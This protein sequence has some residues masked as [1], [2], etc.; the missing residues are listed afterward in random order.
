VQGSSRSRALRLTVTA[1]FAG[2]FVAGAVAVFAA[3]RFLGA[4][5]G[6]SALPVEWRLGGVA[7]LLAGLAAVDLVALR[8]GSYCPLGWRRQTPKALMRLP[9]AP[10]VAAIWG[11]DTGLA[12]T[13]IRVAAL[14]WG[15]LA[16]AFLGLAEWWVG[17]AYGVGFAL[18][19]TVLLWTHGVGPSSVAESPTDPGLA[20]LAG[21]R[22]L[23]QI[24]SAALLAASGVVV[25][26]ALPT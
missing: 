4:A 15:A 13:T 20:A 23:V 24:G 6:V 11:F 22:P 2:A 14:S 3:A 8:R 16:F 21:R 19:V 18:P 12:V 7:V 17:V 26:L 1:S 5:L 25:L 10:A 9:S